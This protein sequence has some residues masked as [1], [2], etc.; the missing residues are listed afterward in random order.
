MMIK[1]E[2][3]S[4]QDPAYREF[5]LNLLPGVTNLIG[6]R[7]PELRKISKKCRLEEL[8]DDTFEEVMLQGMV[9]G[10]FSSFEKFVPACLKF[11]PKIDNWSICDSFVS[12]LAITKKYEKE[13]FLFLKSLISS[14][15]VF[16]RR[17]V[18]VMLLRY[19]IKEEYLDSI[20]IILRTIKKEEYY[21]K[22]AYAW[23]LTELYTEFPEEVIKI[24]EDRAYSIDKWLLGKIVS[25]IKDSRKISLE[26][27][28]KIQFILKERKEYL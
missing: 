19:Y 6:V 8:T 15:H 21:V 7:L 12:G 23:C 27:K 5:S 2:L 25:K 26:Y 20:F 13:M 3:Y 17:F 9:I 14:P 16:T 1:S 11:L 28:N 24:L 18:L 10:H 22:M 4:L